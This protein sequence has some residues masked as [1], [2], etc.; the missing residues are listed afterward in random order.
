MRLR[1]TRGARVTE[2]AAGPNTPTQA[3]DFRTAF[4]TEVWTIIREERQVCED[5]S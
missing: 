5:L 4:S 3:H 1:E 2:P